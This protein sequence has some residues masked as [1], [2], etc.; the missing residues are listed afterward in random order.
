MKALL[1]HNS[2]QKP[3]GEDHVFALESDLLRRHGHTVV[4]YH[5]HNDRLKDKNAPS[6]FVDTIWNREEYR[7]IRNLIQQERPEILHAHNTFPLISP[8]VYYAAEQEGVPVVQTLHNYR[9]LCPAA[10]LFRAGRVCQDCLGTATPWPSVLHACY[11]ES[12]PATGTTAAMITIHKALQTWKKKITVYIALTEFARSKFIEG[13][14]PADKVVVKPNFVSPDSGLGKGDGGYALFVGRLTPEKG[15]GTLLEAWSKIGSKFPLEIIGD[16]PMAPEVAKAASEGSGI[17]W[18]GWLPRERALARMKQAS[19]LIVPST[20][21]EA[22]GMVIIEAFS[23]GLPVI[24]SKIGAMSALI[25]HGRT[26]LHF[27]AGDGL[28]LA[29]QVQHFRDRFERG[30][31][32][33]GQARLEF[34][35]KY[36]GE[37]NYRQLIQIYHRARAGYG[38]ATV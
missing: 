9:L 14:L 23:M 18:L 19:V 26:G 35:A 25:D 17:R 6:L 33:R 5:V 24:A 22:F 36:T 37:L 16:G 3:G 1:V 7:G 4:T 32:M 27:V 8:S 30:D 28:D 10:T 29:A 12:R 15:I 34:E 20:W 11:R 38:L 13:G 21:Y 2:Y 31:Y